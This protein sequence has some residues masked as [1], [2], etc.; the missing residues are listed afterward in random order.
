MI[1]TLIAELS[2]HASFTD[3]EISII[4][5][6]ASPRHFKKG[7]IFTDP[8]KIAREI[9]FIISGIFRYYAIDKEGQEITF[10]FF[11]ENELF[12]DLTSF[13]DEVPCK[14]YIIAET[15]AATITISKPSWRLLMD[16][17]KEWDF[18]MRRVSQETLLKHVAFQ[19]R[20]LMQD[21]SKS[22]TDFVK[23]YPTIAQRVTDLH[24]AS[25]LGITRHSLSRIR[26]NLSTKNKS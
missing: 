11:K 17:V 7:E 6:N 26:K 4:E 18:T 23:L 24:I 8:T 1:D 21:A 25:Y 22:Y 3:E 20:L 12:T 13:H 19:R 9:C 16:A 5:K 14:G 10:L 15:D 2:K